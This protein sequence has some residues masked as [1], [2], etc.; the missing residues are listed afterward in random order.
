MNPNL[1]DDI[2]TGDGPRLRLALCQIK[3]KAWDVA[4]NVQRTMDALEEA[5]AQGAQLAVTPECVFHGYG[6]GENR[7]DTRKRQLEIAEPLDGPR[8][9]AVRELAAKTGMHIVLGFAERAPGDI[10]HNSAA[11]I[12]ASGEILDVYRKVHCRTGEHIDHLGAFTPG[13][14]FVTTE[15]TVDGIPFRIGTMICFDREVP[16]SVRCLRAMGAQ[17]VVCPL[18]WYTESLDEHMDYA[19]NEMVTRC[20]AAENEVFIAVVSHSG[21]FNGGS[22]VVG[23]GGEKLLQLPEEP[24]V[25]VIDIPIEA[26]DKLHAEPFGW[27]GWGYRRPDVYERHLRMT[28]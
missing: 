16:E 4:G 11:I 1:P 9:S 26:C 19:H 15:I 6:F 7:E 21:R 5:A 22:F 10:I 23:P 14:R 12:S 8:I 17:L 2:Y 28:P 20:R 13:D 3:T 25:R 24:E 18:A 27:M